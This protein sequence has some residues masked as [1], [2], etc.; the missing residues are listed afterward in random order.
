ME[1]AL[2]LDSDCLA[3]SAQPQCLAAADEERGHLHSYRRRRYRR[4]EAFAAVDMHPSLA[5]PLS[6]ALS[7]AGLP[8]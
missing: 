6:E 1:S 5:A 2:L 4:F 3:S 7:L 8:A